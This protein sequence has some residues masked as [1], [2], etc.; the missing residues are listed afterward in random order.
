MAKASTVFFDGVKVKVGKAKR[1]F[2]EV[3]EIKALRNLQF[4]AHHQFLE[5]DRDMFLLQV[6]TGYYYKDLQIFTWNQ[7]VKDE[8]YGYFIIGERDKNGNQTIIPLF[9]FPHAS[10]IINKYCTSAATGKVFDKQC[11]VEEPVYNRNLKE[12]AKLASI[13]KNISNKT[14][15]HT[16]AQLWVRFGAE[17]TVLS[18]MMGHTKEETTKNYYDVNIPEIV[19]GTKRV[20][21]DKMGI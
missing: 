10:A 19:E 2:L 21:F 8:E 6:Y 12:L 7:L 4:P 13:S 16:N 18:K 9:K 15:R 3:Q 1:T 5:R 14:A 20:E 17:R 11:F